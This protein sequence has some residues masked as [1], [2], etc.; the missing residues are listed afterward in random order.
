[1]HII[2]VYDDDDDDEREWIILVGSN[3]SVRCVKRDGPRIYTIAI[4]MY[5][6]YTH[7]TYYYK[8]YPK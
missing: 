6:V 5:T 3:A 1:M 4:Y 8:L 7:I 2:Y